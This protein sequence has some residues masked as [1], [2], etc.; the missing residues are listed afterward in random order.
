MTANVIP[1]YNNNKYYLFGYD[2][3]RDVRLAFTPPSSVGKL[4]GDTDNWMWPRQTGDFSVFRVYADANNK[5]AEYSATN[6][7]Y[8][9]KY[10]AEVS[11]DGYKEGDYAM[12][13]G[14]P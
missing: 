4:G 13:I 12:T 10:V 1:F 8:Q 7:P 14:F 9:P 11:L 6:R 3:F 5:P 2:D